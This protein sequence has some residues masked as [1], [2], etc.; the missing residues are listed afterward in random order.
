MISK[1]NTA[2]QGGVH[3]VCEELHNTMRRRGNVA[4]RAAFC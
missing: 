4:M 2:S 3:L 1:H